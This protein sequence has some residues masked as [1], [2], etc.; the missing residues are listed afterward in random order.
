VLAD[1]RTRM[2]S[3]CYASNWRGLGN[4]DDLG[5]SGHNVY[6]T[7]NEDTRVKT[8]TESKSG[9]VTNHHRLSQEAVTQF[10]ACHFSQSNQQAQNL[11]NG[12]NIGPYSLVAQA[13][14]KAFFLN[15]TLMSKA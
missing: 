14:R 13:D 1:C 9:A 15:L 7:S 11:D 3:R 5:G 8:M 10:C 4:E 12:S 2:K 6:M